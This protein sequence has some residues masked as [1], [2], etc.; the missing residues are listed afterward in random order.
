MFDL[1]FLVKTRSK[2]LVSTELW[3]QGSVGR[4]CASDSVPVG[5]ATEPAQTRD[6]SFYTGWRGDRDYRVSRDGASAVSSA[7]ASHPLVGGMAARA[8]AVIS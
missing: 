4:M 7:T 3:Q 8:S 1:L 6:R 2:K 5:C